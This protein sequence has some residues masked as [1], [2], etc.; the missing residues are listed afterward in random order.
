M[1]FIKVYENALS[2][3]LIQDLINWADQ[4]SLEVKFGDK[5]DPASSWGEGRDQFPQGVLGRE[6][7]QMYLRYSNPKLL[8]RINE[9]LFPYFEKYAD[10]FPGVRGSVS[11]E[12]KLQKTFAGSAGYAVFHAEQ[13]G[14]T[15]ATRSTSWLVYL[16]DVEEGGETEFLYQR[17]RQ[18]PKKGDLV[19]WPAS[20][21]HTHRGNPPYSGN[22][23]IITGWSQFLPISL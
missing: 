15:S 3:E 17:H 20:Y 11:Y 22:K 9:E 6:D 19:I 13:G 16:N 10:S 8:E 23:Y 7:I 4:D 5:E 21:T 14:E 1:Q 2:N 18:K 12:V